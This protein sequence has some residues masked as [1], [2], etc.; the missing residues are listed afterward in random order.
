MSLRSIRVKNER[1]KDKQ[2]NDKRSINNN[3][4]NSAEIV[5]KEENKESP[6]IIEKV[7]MDIVK[8]E[9]PEDNNEAAVTIEK[10]DSE[11]I[12]ETK[13]KLELTIKN[14]PVVE[15]KPIVITKMEEPK[16]VDII[17][18]KSLPLEIKSVSP[19][20]KTQSDSEKVNN[21][22]IHEV[23]KRKL[24]IL[25]EGGL[26]VTPVR[27]SVIQQIVSPAFYP[28]GVAHYST[29]CPPPVL[30]PAPSHPKPSNLTVK[31]PPAI[32]N[33]A[34]PPKVV[35]SKSI[36]SYS[37]KTIY[38][39]PK[40]IFMQSE[41]N[42]V[43]TPKFANSGRPRPSGG[44]LLD[45]SVHSP[46][47]P[48]VE[49]MRIP[50]IPSTSHNRD[51]V[52]KNL[53]K[54]S[55]SSSSSSSS[56]ARLGSNL[57]ITLVPPH[58]KPLNHYYPQSKLKRVNNYTNKIDVPKYPTSKPSCVMPTTNSRTK[59]PPLTPT[60]QQIRQIRH[61]ES[62]YKNYPT[63][64]PPTLPP[65][66]PPPSFFDGHKDVP[67]FLP[68][69]LSLIA[70]PMYYMQTIYSNN[71]GLTPPPTPLYPSLTTPEP[72]S[73]LMAKSTRLAPYQLQKMPDNGSPSLHTRKS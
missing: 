69:Y 26:E 23:K 72:F 18:I 40:D 6:I 28:D 71:I 54:D 70:D 8:K 49:I 64:L 59:I 31:F 22:Y 3:D 46:Q 36:Y 7:Q 41:L 65:L 43:I 34:I 51:S 60:P 13:I 73:D 33:G 58:N 52:T 12:V 38:G 37:E 16:P 5:V 45:L 21:V 39:N 10:I 14:E 68:P 17:K 42:P 4:I 56:K 29:K 62:L 63:P 57:E 44:D 47:K 48:V 25:K 32:I 61:N 66:V 19:K 53:Y 55:S 30:N 9:E 2:S 20:I 35:Q 50:Q 15:E 24:D 1:Q 27:P 67:P 11:N